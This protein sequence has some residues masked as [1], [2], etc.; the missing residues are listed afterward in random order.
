MEWKVGFF[1]LVIW[2]CAEFDFALETSN[3]IIMILAY[4][5]LSGNDTLITDHYSLLRKW[6][7]YL[8]NNS[9]APNDQ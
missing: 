7:Q 2:N 8:S 6:G 1:L 5:Q 4:T 9:L 3:M